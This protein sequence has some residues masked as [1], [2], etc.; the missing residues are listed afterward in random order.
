M[1]RERRVELSVV[2]G[3]IVVDFPLLFLPSSA[4]LVTLL[5]PYS[6]ACGPSIK[7]HVSVSLVI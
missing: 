7:Q 4:L 3:G 2:V 1:L 6:V 5:V